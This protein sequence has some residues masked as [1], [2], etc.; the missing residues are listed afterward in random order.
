MSHHHQF[1][2]CPGCKG[3]ETCR[4]IATK[5]KTTNMCESCKKDKL[6]ED[7]AAGSTGAGA[8]AGMRGRMFTAIRE[9]V[10]KRNKVANIPVIKYKNPEVNLNVRTKGIAEKKQTFG[11]FLAEDATSG[12]D[13]VD[14][15]S[16]LSK[17]ADVADELD[18]DD[19]AV[20]G[21]ESDDGAIT[22]VYIPRE[23]AKDFERAL[24]DA[25]K[26]TKETHEQEIAGILYDLKDRFKIIDVKWPTVQEDEEQG[27]GGSAT[28]PPAGELG[29]NTGTDPAGGLGD[30]AAPGDPAALGADP[31]LDPQGVPLDPNA[32][33][34][35]PPVD[36]NAVI[37]QIL[38]MLRADAEARKA[39]SD[40]KAAAAKAD[41]AESAG[42]VAAIK[43]QGEEG[44]LDAE[45]FFKGKKDEKKES[46]RIKMLAKFRQ[47]TKMSQDSALPAGPSTEVVGG[48]EEKGNDEDEE[49]VTMTR[50]QLLSILSRG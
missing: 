31:A 42:K 36:Q 12:F 20:F 10:Q 23:Q 50:R 38:D 37:T 32:P 34:A 47:E 28:N 9:V 39:E 45:A 44:V 17:N 16:K 43:L 26:N 13:S 15:I 35:E 3:T 49:Q 11:N 22:K 48:D 18:G 24:G 46:D 6:S 8:I 21:M 41:E 7:A 27:V 30:P 5:T 1:N 25:L 2:T 29:A 14:V 33:P 4:C 40:A 19:M